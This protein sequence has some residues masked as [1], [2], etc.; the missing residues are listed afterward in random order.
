MKLLRIAP[1]LQGYRQ[2]KGIG[3]QPQQHEIAQ[4]TAQLLDAQPI[5]VCGLSHHAELYRSCLRSSRTLIS[6]KIGTKAAERQQIDTK[7]RKAQSLGEGADADRHEICHGKTAADDLSAT[8]QR[9]N[10]RHHAGKLRRRQNRQNGGAEQRGDLGA[11][12]C[13]NQHAVA[14]HRRHIDQHAEK[15]RRKASLER[16][17]EDEQR[18]QQ[19]QGEI[20]HRDRDVRQ[21]LAKQEFKPGNRRHIKVG[22]RPEFLLPHDGKR[23]QDR[24]KQRQ[25]HGHVR[26]HHRIDAVEILIVLEPDFDIGGRRRRRHRRLHGRIR[27]VQLMHALQ[28]AAN[29]FR[30]ERH[31]AI[32]QRADPDRTSALDVAA[33]VRR[34]F[35][36]GRDV[37][38]LE[39]VVELGIVIER[40]LL[41]RNS[42]SP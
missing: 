30:P 41:R 15:Q 24:R 42:S 19:H 2:R 23:H 6:V 35:N 8:S 1:R 9:G 29:G 10:R 27:Q 25:Q 31:R 26:R 12:E 32:D 5:D 33:E 17:L 20:G 11:R 4:E 14:G 7:V 3:H 40:R 16:N 34:D 39:T 38:A 28:I 13:R 36:R 18:H 37:S 21:L 22:D